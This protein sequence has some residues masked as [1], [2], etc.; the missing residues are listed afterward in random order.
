MLF[1]NEIIDIY[2]FVFILILFL[3]VVE[4]VFG[5]RFFGF[6]QFIVIF[7][8][9]VSGVVEVVEKAALCEG[10]FEQ[11]VETRILNV[12]VK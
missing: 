10:F 4:F 12:L 11:K 7:C 2:F 3:F 6:H 1:R 5:R 9:L 8:F